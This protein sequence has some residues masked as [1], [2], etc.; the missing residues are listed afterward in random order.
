MALECHEV[1]P[2]PSAKDGATNRLESTMKISLDP[3]LRYRRI[4]LSARCIPIGLAL[5]AVACN[6]TASPTP[7]ANVIT[8]HGADFS[9]DAPA[10]IPAGMTTVNF[11][12]DGPGLHQAQ[13]V[14]LDSGKTMTDLRAALAQ[15]GALPN[16]VVQLGGPNAVDPG[17]SANA[18]L[19]LPAGNY[20]L[21]CV[22]NVPGGVPHFMKGMLQPLTVTGNGS[23]SQ[24]APG[25]VADETVTMDNFAFKLSAPL[26]AGTHTFKVMNSDGQPHELELVRLAPGK[27]AADMLAWLQAQNGPP[28]RQALGGVAIVSPAV[29]AAYFTASFTSGNYMLLCFVNDAGDGRP[30]FAH[31]MVLPITIP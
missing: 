26:T 27:T 31:G 14:R 8:I 29:G 24:T 20:A 13:L 21:L 16:W 15:P 28:P 6:D 5:L 25:P 22:V 30:H 10:T 7:V 11:V 17:M 4:L 2:V 18:T 12:N 23:A 1:L 3:P 9:Y 19:N